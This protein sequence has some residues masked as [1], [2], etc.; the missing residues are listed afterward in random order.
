MTG[1]TDDSRYQYTGREFDAE[2]GLNYDR[3][4]YFDSNIGRFIGQDPI[5]ITATDPI[6]MV[7]AIVPKIN[8]TDFAFLEVGLQSTL[9]LEQLFRSTN[10][11]VVS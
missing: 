7:A 8:S 1:A 11:A 6:V 3:T 10:L 5:G 2:T 9:L 4:T